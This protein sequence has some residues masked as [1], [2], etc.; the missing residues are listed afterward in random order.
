MKTRSV[1]TLGAALASSIFSQPGHGQIAGA[2]YCSPATVYN[3]NPSPESLDAVERMHPLLSRARY[4]DAVRNEQ[5]EVVLRALRTD[6]L[7]AFGV[8]G[9]G[10]P[11][12]QNFLVELDET[13]R[14]LPALPNVGSPARAAYVNTVLQSARFTPTPEID[15][16][17][18]FAGERTID[19]GKQPAPSQ[20]ALCWSALSIDQVLFHIGIGLQPAALKRLARF[21]VSWANYRKHGYTRQPLELLVFR[22]RSGVHDTLPGRTQW[23][24]GHLSLGVEARWRDSLT[25]VNSTVVE[26]FGHLWYWNNYSQYSGV[27]AIVSV[28]SGRRPGFG[29]MVH[30]ARS[31]RGGV[32]F[33]RES[34]QWRPGVVVSTD[35]YGLLERS[36][37]AVDQ[38]LAITRGKTLLGVPAEK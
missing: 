11:E 29:G 37:R 9:V 30:V 5:W 38:G 7:E 14:A 13:L 34:K 17:S 26:T 15:S 32:L 33:R 6:A 10:I 36:K 18:L 35:L 4:A 25:S 2:A 21:N 24:L 23:L 16:Y 28:P 1:V 3:Q 12:Q 19:I 22:G 20:R 27:S 31:M 8:A